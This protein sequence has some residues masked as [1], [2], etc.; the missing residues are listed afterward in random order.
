MRT[1][2]WFR[3]G[4][5][6]SSVPVG[7]HLAA[8]WSWRFIAIVAA[9]AVAVLLI[10]QLSFIVIPLLIAV[11]LAVLAAPVAQWLRRYRFPGWLAT[12][13]TIV[14]F[15]SAVTALIWLVV[16]QIR[17]DWASL[18]ERSV[19]AYEDFIVY[20]LESPLHVTETQ[21]N[22][23]LEQL[24]E[25]L[26]LNS[27]WILSGALSISSS[28]GSV[29]VGAGLALFALV[30]FVHDGERILRWLIGLLPQEARAPVAGASQRGWETLTRFVSVQIFV[31]VVDA[32]GIG[33]GAFFLGLPL[34]TPI[35]V[36]VFLG[37]FVP[38]IGAFAAGGLAAFIALVYEGPIAALIM[39]AIV[40]AVQQI[41]GQILQPLVM[42]AAVR[43][44]PLAVVLAVAAGGFLAGIP[45]VLF[46]VP[47]VAYLNVFIGYLS[48]REWLSD[49]A[50]TPW[51]QPKV[52]L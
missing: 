30:F 34:V 39:I 23:W 13:L 22:D 20:L 16:E 6:T 17:Q 2:R 7:I 14:G 42:G 33:L 46:A 31:A 51:L 32:I 25:Q 11:L 52:G 49:P 40:L 37:G 29:L 36:A 47:I 38:I 27:A 19:L 24:A 41:E 43:V 3:E 15:L 12:L 35:A 50:I 9:L 10:I 26:N 44:H 48:R 1:P 21:L 28:V 4:T 45:G 5:K 18:Q 8:A